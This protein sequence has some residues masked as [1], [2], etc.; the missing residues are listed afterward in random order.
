MSLLQA[1]TAWL[2]AH[3]S[4]SGLS[5][6]TTFSLP[7]PPGD[8]QIERRDSSLTPDHS[9]IVWDETSQAQKPLL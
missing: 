1:H 8:I 7:L 4:R 3:F 6:T 5:A 2:Q 9:G